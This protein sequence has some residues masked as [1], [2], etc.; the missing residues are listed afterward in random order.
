MSQPAGNPG[1]F[2]QGLFWCH[3]PS[4]LCS[5]VPVFLQASQM[6]LFHL[7]AAGS[8]PPLSEMLAEALV[9]LVVAARSV[10]SSTRARKQ[11]HKKKNSKTTYHTREVK[12]GRE[13]S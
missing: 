6:A 2:C 1:A 8:S 3:F 10:Y 12:E 4:Q 5:L 7:E 13:G 9:I 11:S